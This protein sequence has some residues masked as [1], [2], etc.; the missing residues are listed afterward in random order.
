MHRST[1]FEKDARLPMSPTCRFSSNRGFRTMLCWLADHGLA[2]QGI[3]RKFFFSEYLLQYY[4]SFQSIVKSARLGVILNFISLLIEVFNKFQ[5]KVLRWIQQTIK[6]SK[7]DFLAAA[8]N[9]HCELSSQ[10]L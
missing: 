3:H 6:K 7:T 8:S 10:V 2:G 9:P 1:P 4:D 5:G